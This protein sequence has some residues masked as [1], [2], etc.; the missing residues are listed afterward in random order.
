MYENEDTV[1]AIY[2]MGFVWCIGALYALLI[3]ENTFIAALFILL[4]IGIFTYPFFKFLFVELVNKYPQL[5]DKEIFKSYEEKQSD[6]WQKKMEK[7]R[8]DIDD[9]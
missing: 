1:G 8:T 2:L 6:K 9:K 7:Y 3:E 4:V 5:L